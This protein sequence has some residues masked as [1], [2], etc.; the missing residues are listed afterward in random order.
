VCCILLYH[1][2]RWDTSDHR[3][4]HFSPYGGTVR[5]MGLGSLV[6][7]SDVSFGAEMSGHFRPIWTVSTVEVSHCR[8]VSGPKFLVTICNAL[9]VKLQEM[10]ETRLDLDTNTQATRVKPVRRTTHLLK[11]ADTDS[12]WLGGLRSLVLIKS[13]QV[14]HPNRCGTFG[15]WVVFSLGVHVSK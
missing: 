7:G 2:R 10:C 1:K 13:R 9:V 3:V 11:W 14:L 12:L 4:G 15:Q 6:V 5:T 8:S